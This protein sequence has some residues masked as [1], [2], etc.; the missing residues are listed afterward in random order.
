M[1]CV[2][3]KAIKPWLGMSNRRSDECRKSVCLAISWFLPRRVVEGG[4]ITMGKQ[5]QRLKYLFAVARALD[6]AVALS[7][8]KVTLHLG[9]ADPGSR[10]W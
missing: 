4:G 10:T 5:A 7:Y 8:G 1:P 3:V 2:A 9:L 6:A